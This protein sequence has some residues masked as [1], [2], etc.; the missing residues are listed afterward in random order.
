[1]VSVWLAWAVTDVGQCDQRKQGGRLAQG[2][3]WVLFKMVFKIVFKAVI[4]ACSR[5][6]QKGP[7]RSKVDVL[8]VGRP[9]GI[10]WVALGD[11]RRRVAVARVLGPGI[12]PRHG[13][14]ALPRGQEGRGGREVRQHLQ[15][16]TNITVKAAMLDAS[17]RTENVVIECVLSDHDALIATAL[18]KTA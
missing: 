2:G 10:C 16:G 4:K 15:T 12:G 7:D 14:T 6:V 18:S 3:R 13:G 9:P 17:K 8:E 11:V 5:R 1:M